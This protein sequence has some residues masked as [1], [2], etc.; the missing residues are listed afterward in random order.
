VALKLPASADPS[1]SRSGGW[2]PGRSGNPAGRPKGLPNFKTL[3]ASLPDDE[4]GRR[5]AVATTLGLRIDAVPVGLDRLGLLLWMREQQAYRG[6]EAA[7]ADM[8]ERALPKPRRHE[9]SGPGGTPLAI[10]RVPDSANPA[11]A[12]AMAD[13]MAAVE[14][15]SATD[16]YEE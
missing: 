16:Q 7:L 3:L 4:D 9:V 8:F 12:D 11:E 5:A 14:A 6:N 15:A 1:R 2:A 13:V 10:R